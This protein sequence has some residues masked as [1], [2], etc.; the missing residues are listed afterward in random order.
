MG[1][2][3]FRSKEGGSAQFRIVIKHHFRERWH[4]DIGPDKDGEIRR[5]LRSALRGKVLKRTQNGF[6]VNISGRQ[7]ICTIGPTGAWVFITLLRRGMVPKT[8][9]DVASFRESAKDEVAGSGGGM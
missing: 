2:A 5:R 7:A 8:D 9:D 1:K 4:D 6:A 3:K